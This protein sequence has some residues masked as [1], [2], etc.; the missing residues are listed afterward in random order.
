MIIGAVRI[1]QSQCSSLDRHL[2]DRVINTKDNVTDSWMVNNE[3]KYSLPG[4]I[5]KIKDI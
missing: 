4:I 3:Q 5:A 1:V 2:H